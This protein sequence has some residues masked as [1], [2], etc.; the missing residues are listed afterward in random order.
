MVKW[1]FVLNILWLSSSVT[2]EPV[3]FEILPKVCIAPTDEVCEMTLAI[4]WHFDSPACLV[5]ANAPDAHLLCAQEMELFSLKV[6]MDANM[7]FLLL[8]ASSAKILGRQKIEL[9]RKESPP[10]QQRRLSWSLF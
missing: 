1:A 3:T 2:A 7:E 9:M 10:L 5:N 6:Q 8:D 4:H